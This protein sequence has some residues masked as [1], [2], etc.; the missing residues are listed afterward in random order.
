MISTYGC[1]PGQFPFVISAE[2]VQTARGSGSWAF[3]DVVLIFVVVAM[4]VVID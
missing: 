1:W 4:L 3:F 2:R